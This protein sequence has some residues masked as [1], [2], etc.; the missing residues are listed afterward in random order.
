VPDLSYDQTIYAWRLADVKHA[1]YRNGQDPS[2]PFALAQV[3]LAGNL[4][5]CTGYAPIVAA[6]QSA[7]EEMDASR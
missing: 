2:P 6:V 1:L 3:G 5:R 4:C 7:A